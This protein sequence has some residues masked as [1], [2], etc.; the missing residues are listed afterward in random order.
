[1]NLTVTATINGQTLSTKQL[2]A[3]EG[4]VTDAVLGALAKLDGFGDLKA[5]P[6]PVAREIGG[7]T[8]VGFRAA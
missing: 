5:E 7:G 8:R 1:M 6:L 3:L 4:A 2:G